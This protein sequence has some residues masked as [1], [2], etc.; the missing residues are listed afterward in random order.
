MNDDKKLVS[1]ALNLTK[2]IVN[3]QLAH[4]FVIVKREFFTLRVRSVEENVVFF[5][6]KYDDEFNIKRINVVVNDGY[7]KKAWFG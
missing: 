2:E 7:V 4:A 1:I 3:K 6:D 5:A